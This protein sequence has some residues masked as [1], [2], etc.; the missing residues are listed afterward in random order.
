M[1]EETKIVILYLLLATFFVLFL[2]NFMLVQVDIHYFIEAL[3]IWLSLALPIRLFHNIV[4]INPYM[5]KRMRLV[6]KF[7]KII[8]NPV[9]LVIKLLLSRTYWKPIYMWILKKIHEV[10]FS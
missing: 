4:K 5:V 9:I 3:Q 10:E 7:S 1:F 8:T 6:L 2:T